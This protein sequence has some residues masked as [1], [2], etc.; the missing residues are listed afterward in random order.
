MSNNNVLELEFSDFHLTPIESYAKK[1]IDFDKSLTI[2]YVYNSLVQVVDSSTIEER[3]EQDF[4]IEDYFKEKDTKEIKQEVKEVEH[5]EEKVSAFEK[6][7]LK[8]KEKK[9]KEESDSNYE[10]ISIFDDFG[11]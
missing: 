8:K 6:F 10:Q 5:K 4:K 7:G 11:D 3:S 2:K 9:E 1:N